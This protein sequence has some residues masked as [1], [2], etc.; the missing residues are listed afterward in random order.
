MREHQLGKLRNGV[1]Q[2]IVYKETIH[3]FGLKDE[4][5]VSD[6]FCNNCNRL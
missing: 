4:R 2:V 1:R 6:W 5:M 3:N